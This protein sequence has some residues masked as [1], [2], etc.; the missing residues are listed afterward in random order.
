MQELIASYLVQRKA[1]SLPLLGDFSIV[2]KPAEADMANS[3]MF[4]P[5]DEILFHETTG[6]LSDLFTRYIAG[7]M[8]IS[9]N[10]AEERFNHWCLHSKA[11]LDSGEKITFDTIGSLEKNTAG[12]IFFQ[13]T[14][15]VI[16]YETV[17]AKRPIHNNN[18][19]HVVLV[20]D[21]ETTSAAMNEFYRDEVVIEKRSPWKMWAIILFGI[22][23]LVLVLYFYSHSFS[24]TG[25][26][27]Q[28]SFPVKEPPATYY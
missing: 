24:E 6:Y 9:Q 8:N 16:L 4:P 1:C 12:A 23:L 17:P 28:S 14:K 25:V 22:S 15:G 19:D 21:R 27:N 7:L 26:G 5:T 11:K 20:G 3:Q 10:E 13:R 18:D 2:T